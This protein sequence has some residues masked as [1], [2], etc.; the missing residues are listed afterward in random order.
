MGY[1]IFTI[2]I[3]IVVLYIV[4][5]QLKSARR[6]Y[7]VLLS[8]GQQARKDIRKII[9]TINVLLLNNTDLGL[10]DLSILSR[11]LFEKDD[12]IKYKW[13]ELTG[14]KVDEFF[15][16]EGDPPQPIVINKIEDPIDEELNKLFKKNFQIE[17]KEWKESGEKMN[18]YLMI[19]RRDFFIKNFPNKIRDIS[20]NYSFDLNGNESELLDGFIKRMSSI[21]K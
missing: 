13:K 5:N 15:E 20:L 6:S 3:L 7:E 10:R 14:Y 4:N 2:I 16:E 18:T 17:K 12:L 8:E 9:K 21:L 1:L 11:N 19:A